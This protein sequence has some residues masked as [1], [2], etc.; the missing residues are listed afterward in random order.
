M[1]IKFNCSN[2]ECRRHIEANAAEAGRLVHCPSCGQS[3]QVPDPLPKSVLAPFTTVRSQSTGDNFATPVA[4]Q[5]G[6]L[7][8]GWSAGAVLFGLIL[9][10]LFLRTQRALPQHLSTKLDEV[11]F[12]GEFRDAPVANH[13]GTALLYAQDSITGIDIFL[14]NLATL[15]R[16][17]LET[18]RS[19]D[20]ARVR[21][22]KLCGWSPNDHY[23]AFAVSEADGEDRRVVLCDALPERKSTALRL[24][25]RL[26]KGLGLQQIA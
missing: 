10:S 22:F 25:I 13:A 5:F 7:L 2:P 12:S 9:G 1:D 19:A 11:Y 4:R 20:M 8:L 16:N 24:A 14:L 26:N 23:L 17:R 21:A 3:I 18:V 6:R 15:E